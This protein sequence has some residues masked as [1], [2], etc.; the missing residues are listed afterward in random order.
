MNILIIS[1]FFP[2]HIGGVETAS[3]NTAKQ[4]VTRGHNVV[5]LTSK[6]EKSSPKFQEMNGFLVYRFKSFYPPEIK[7]IPQISSFG[8]IPMGIL[9]LKKILK[10]HNIQIIHAEGRLFPITFI[11]ALMNK[12]IFKRTMYLTVQGRLKIGITG[13]YENVFD[14][15]I[16]K[17]LYQKIEKIICVSNSLKK[18]LISLRINPTKLK[19]IPKI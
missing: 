4:L 7:G 18:R 15:I 10:K 5:I 11:T 9:K 8:I 12:L 2:P 6:T 13:L 16:T 17:F 14:M 19:V 1:H 3:Y